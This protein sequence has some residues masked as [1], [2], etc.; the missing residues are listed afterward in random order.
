VLLSYVLGPA[1]MSLDLWPGA[2]RCLHI[3]RDGNEARIR[4]RQTRDT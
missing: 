4:F 3:V 2:P 1:P